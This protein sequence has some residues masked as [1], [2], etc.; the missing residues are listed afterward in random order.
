L[1]T[2]SAA[3]FDAWL[4][5][6]SCAHLRA[7]RACACEALDVFPDASEGWR[8]GIET[9]RD[10]CEAAESKDGYHVPT[11]L[12]GESAQ[13]LVHKYGKLLGDW[14]GIVAAARGSKQRM[15]IRL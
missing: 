5:E 14:G 6:A 9:I 7:L 11:D 10:L 8:E 15:A 13:D 3:D 12:N 4:L 1:G 2:C